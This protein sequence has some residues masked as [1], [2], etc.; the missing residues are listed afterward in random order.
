MIIFMTLRLF[1]LIIIIV[2]R[3]LEE[4]GSHAYERRINAD[5]QGVIE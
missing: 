4:G 1:S 5:D 3:M 2:L